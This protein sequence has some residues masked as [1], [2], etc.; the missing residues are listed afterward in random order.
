MP[1]YRKRRRYRP[2]LLV[3]NITEADISPEISAAVRARSA[4]FYR[5]QAIWFAVK[6]WGLTIF[7]A[8]AFWWL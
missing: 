5:R 7:C 4:R 6:G 3:Q 1:P 8:L 2:R